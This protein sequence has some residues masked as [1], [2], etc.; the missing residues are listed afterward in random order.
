[1]RSIELRAGLPGPLTK[2][3]FTSYLYGVPLSAAPGTTYVYSNDGYYL[4]ARVIEKAVGQSYFDWVNANVLAPVGVT[5]AV[6]AATAASGRRPNEVF[7]D[8]PGTGCSVLTPERNVKLPD[9]YGGFTYMEDL[10][11]P[12][13]IVM[14]AESLAKFAGTYNVAGVGVRTA[15]NWRAGSLPGTR[16]LVESLPNGIDFAFT[17]NKRVNNK[18]AEFDIVSLREYLEGRLRQSP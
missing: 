2:S 16:S 3:Q 12:S 15:G 7:Y 8:D 1:M 18:G 6:V 14:S 11:G 17:F 10:D 9:P 5:D 13:A 4:L